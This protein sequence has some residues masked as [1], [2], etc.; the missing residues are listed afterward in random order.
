MLNNYVSNAHIAS[1]KKIVHKKEDKPEL[2]YPL[3][4][5]ILT[6]FYPPDYAA[7]GQLIEEL[8][9]NL[10]K[11]G[12]DVRI[13][14]GQP[15]YA[16]QKDS[17]PTKERMGK[18]LIQRSRISRILNGRIRGKALNGFV[19]FLRAALH[20]I[21][22]V[23]RNDILLLTTAPPFLPLIGYL[24]KLFFDV[25][26]VCLIYDLYPD[27]AVEL[28]VV[29][30]HNLLVKWW[31]W[32]NKQVWQ[33]ADS[34]IVLSSTMKER[35]QDKCPEIGDKIAV[36][37]NWANPDRI[38]PIAKQDNWF[39][40]KFNLVNKF[41]VLYSGNMGRCHEMDTILATAQL[42]QNEPVEFVFIG[43]GA[44]REACIERVRQI[45]LD[46]CQFLP[47]QDKQDLPYSL[48]ACDLSLVTISHGMEGLVAPSKFYG[49]LAAGRPVAAICEPHSYLRS[50]IAEAN[51][52]AAFSNGDAVD[53]A[54][55]IRRLAADRELAQQMGIA[56]RYYLQFNFTPEIIARQ[57]L[58]TLQQALEAQE[59]RQTERRR[60][61]NSKWGQR[62]IKRLSS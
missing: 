39:A 58:K 5:S 18:I 21:K 7:T 24:A 54:R 40:H 57:Y 44:K 2:V 22:K 13:F 49:M 8:A 11:L 30:A 34:I 50:L 46:N 19:F 48:T 61:R 41:T 33:N 43:G 25:P 14:T 52:G 6:Q 20:L 42:L 15:G 10:E 37:H 16:F 45:G 23:N 9:I 31:D 4:L 1:L 56:G 29:P 28:N 3:R 38:V 36:I 27:I 47:Y 35:V 53:I 60:R 32:L 12:N 59:I 17:A 62:R 51:C 26:Y 55:F